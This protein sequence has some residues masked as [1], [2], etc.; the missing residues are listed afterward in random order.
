MFSC[1]V[2]DNPQAGKTAVKVDI[3]LQAYTD[4]NGHFHSPAWASNDVVALVNKSTGERATAR[5]VTAGTEK[6]TFIFK[7]TQP[8]KDDVLSAEYPAIN[9]TFE[10]QTSY[11]QK[12]STEKLTLVYKNAIE[13]KVIEDDTYPM[14]LSGRTVLADGVVYERYTLTKQDAFVHVVTADMTRSDITLDAVISNDICPNPCNET[15]NNGKRLRETLSEVVSRRKAEGRKVLA[16][17]N[18]DYYATVPG[19]LLSCHVQDG[20]AVFINNPYERVKEPYF[21]YG[22]TLFQDR[23]LSTEARTISCKARLGAKEVEVF[24]VND[25]IVGLSPKAAS[26]ARPYQGANVYT[27]RFV[28]LPFPEKPTLTNK[29]GTNA[30]FIVA[31]ADDVLKVNTGYIESKI[32]AV[33]DGRKSSLGKAPF[34]TQKGEWVLQLTG[35]SAEAFADAKVGDAIAFRADIAIGGQTK[36]IR[37]HVGGKYR[38]VTMGMPSTGTEDSR[39]A[40]RHT[41]VALDKDGKELR[42]I[43]IEWTSMFRDA[44]RICILLGCYNVVKCDGGGSACMWINKNGGQVV[45]KSTD[46]RGPERSNMNYIHIVQQ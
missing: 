19:I 37:S 5:P 9:P 12:V 41:M 21:L 14:M 17:I 6:S 38:F 42:L 32:T 24:S 2:K 33:Y 22:I 16:A 18:G 26:G 4:E 29:I 28:Q 13:P 31:R 25:T 34:V 44:S 10:G 3:T 45:Q 40:T 39:P 1:S 20:E 23:T 27:H 7:M 36:P 46:S 43:T 15:T 8:T 30:L 11:S 35:E